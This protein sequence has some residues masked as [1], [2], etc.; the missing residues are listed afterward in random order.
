[1][2]L[3]LGRSSDCKSISQLCY[4]VQS[5]N[6]YFYRHQ[7]NCSFRLSDLTLQQVLR[8]LTLLSVGDACIITRVMEEENYVNK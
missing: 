7:S 1:M 2:T 8:T 3:I 6:F 4:E 5:Q